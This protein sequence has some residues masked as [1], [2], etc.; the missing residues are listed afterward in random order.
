MIVFLLGHTALGWGD[1]ANAR[2]ERPKIQP[3]FA[4][5][6]SDQAIILCVLHS[7]RNY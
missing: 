5:V 3:I 1:L 2:L 4:N 7:H 6:H